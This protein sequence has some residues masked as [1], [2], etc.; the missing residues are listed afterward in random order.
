[1]SGPLQFFALIGLLF[2]SMRLIAAI[3]AVLII[4]LHLWI[5]TS[6]WW[7]L[8]PGAI[9]AFWFYVISND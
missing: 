4:V 5:G 1:M 3:L 9:F 7:M 6:L 8:I 2:F